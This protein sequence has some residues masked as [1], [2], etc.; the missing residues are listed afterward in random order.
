MLAFTAT[1]MPLSRP[2]ALGGGAAGVLPSGGGGTSAVKA[3]VTCEAAAAACALRSRAAAVVSPARNC[4]NVCISVAAMQKTSQGSR[5]AR[6][7][8][9]SCGWQ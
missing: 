3:F 8:Q 2:S 1:G 5:D 4:S 9:V 6:E 7:T